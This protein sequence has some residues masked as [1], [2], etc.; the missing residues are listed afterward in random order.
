MPFRGTKLWDKYKHLVTFDDY[1]EYN[2]KSA[3]LEKDPERKLIDEFNMFKYQWKYYTSDLYKGIRDFACGDTL[4][5]RF[6]EL[7]E[8]FAKKVQ[9]AIA[10]NPQSIN[11]KKLKL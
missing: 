11:L 9:D 10:K 6:L 7:K 3:F 5:L 2:S 4:H 1:K 8:M